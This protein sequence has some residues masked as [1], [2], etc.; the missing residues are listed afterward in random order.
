MPVEWVARALETAE[1]RGFMKA[2][3]DKDSK[4]ILGFACL[5]I[6]GGEVMSTVQMAMQ[7]ALTWRQVRDATF[8]H[9]CTA[10]ALN[11][12]FAQLGDD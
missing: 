2:V 1:T 9:P 12:L 11:N 8:A 10:E 4:E 6:E 5:G 7:G 3:V